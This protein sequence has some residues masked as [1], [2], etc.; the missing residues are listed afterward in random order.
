MGILNMRVFYIYLN[1]GDRI[2]NSDK[3][4]I[5]LVSQL[6][7]LHLHNKT[8]TRCNPTRKNCYRL[9]VY[10]SDHI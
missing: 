3:Y 5:L 10:M 9:L 7:V 6:E 2:S 1:C 4:C 8:P